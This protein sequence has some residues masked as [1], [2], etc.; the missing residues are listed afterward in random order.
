MSDFV[1]EGGA[2]FDNI[3]S[4]DNLTLMRE[5]MEIILK[6]ELSRRQFDPVTE[7]VIIACFSILITFGALGNGLVIFVVSNVSGTVITL[8][9]LHV[10]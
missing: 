1:F 10:L 9:S 7:A 5:W 2:I 6:K 8:V 3:N 4:T